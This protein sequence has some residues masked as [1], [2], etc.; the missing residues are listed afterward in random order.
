MGVRDFFALSTS[1]RLDQ[2]FTFIGF[3]MV[4]QIALTKSELE[5]ILKVSWPEW[6]IKLMEQVER[7]KS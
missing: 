6:K 5:E 1:L 4:E 2:T 7:E 3:F